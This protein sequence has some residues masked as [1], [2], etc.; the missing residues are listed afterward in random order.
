MRP[1]TCSPVVTKN[2]QLS[3]FVIWQSIDGICGKHPES[4][5]TPGEPIYWRF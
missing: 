4:S 1:A 2:Y 5:Q 3:H